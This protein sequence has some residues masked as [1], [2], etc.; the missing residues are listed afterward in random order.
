MLCRIR[1]IRWK[2]NRLVVRVSH[3]WVDKESG[4]TAEGTLNCRRATTELRIHIHYLYPEP[5]SDWGKRDKHPR[6]LEVPVSI[7]PLRSSQYPLALPRP[8]VQTRRPRKLITPGK[9]SISKQSFERIASGP[10]S[11]CKRNARPL[12][13]GLRSHL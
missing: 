12:G 6:R 2:K 13:L 9:K 5:R 8:H 4:Q 7:T 10:T 11:H 1:G 3:R